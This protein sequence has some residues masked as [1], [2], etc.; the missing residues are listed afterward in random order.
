MLVHR[1]SYT[2]LSGRERLKD[3]GESPGC[4]S[5]PIPTCHL[6]IFKTGH[7]VQCKSTRSIGFSPLLQVGVETCAAYCVAAATK[8][9]G[10]FEALPTALCSCK[11]ALLIRYSPRRIQQTVL[12]EA[13]DGQDPPRPAQCGRRPPRPAVSGFLARFAFSS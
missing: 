5:D 7:A 2:R 1:A 9:S 12:P 3:D 11:A 4:S 10:L 13:L 6:L 8:T